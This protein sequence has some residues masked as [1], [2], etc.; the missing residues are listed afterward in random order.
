M[1]GFWKQ[2]L[3]DEFPESSVSPTIKLASPW[4]S[5]EFKK[6]LATVP[7][8]HQ[9]TEPPHA[10]EVRNADLC[11]SGR[12]LRVPTSRYTVNPFV[13]AMSP[14]TKTAHFGN[15]KSLRDS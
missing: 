12:M 6:S 4:K 11:I 1:S 14:G 5:L 2:M 9:R 13:W 10:T 15:I 3:K 8:Q 7:P